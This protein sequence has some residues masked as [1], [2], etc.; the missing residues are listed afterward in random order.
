[1][2]TKQKNGN[3]VPI[4]VAKARKDS[5][6]KASAAEIMARNTETLTRLKNLSTQKGSS[7][8]IP[9]PQ[10]ARWAGNVESI[11][12][13]L[14]AS[15]YGLQDLFAASVSEDFKR[16]YEDAQAYSKNLSAMQNAESS[17]QVV[18]YKKYLEFIE[19]VDA[20]TGESLP[21]LAAE[22][23]EGIAL[24]DG[25]ADIP[26]GCFELARQLEIIANRVGKSSGLIDQFRELAQ[27]R[28]RHLCSGGSCVWPDDSYSF[29]DGYYTPR[30]GKNIGEI[31]EWGGEAEREVNQPKYHNQSVES[32]QE[33]PDDD[34]LLKEGKRSLREKYIEHPKLRRLANN[35]YFIDSECAIYNEYTAPS[36]K[37][38]TLSR[39]SDSL[40]ALP[41]HYAGV[42]IDDFDVDQHI[43]GRYLIRDKAEMCVDTEYVFNLDSL[44]TSEGPEI[45]VAEL[46]HGFHLAIFLYPNENCDGLIPIIH[47]CCDEM[48]H[49]APLDARTISMEAENVVFPKMR[50]KIFPYQTESLM[51]YLKAAVASG[52]LESDWEKSAHLLKQ[53]PLWNVES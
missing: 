41:V 1:M 50:P 43:R 28:E 47:L 13:R 39:F 25:N 44:E 16:S 53:C 46:V 38:L 26:D 31:V 32:L 17:R 22:L 33:M 14:K 24:I 27:V 45:E 23:S 30:P 20:L 49:V 52:E 2:T 36:R 10:R 34:P 37:S 5:K 18:G 3:V 15:G 7:G 40:A 48:A 29:D 12:K 11:V 19:L 42:M 35:T 4:A 6:G 51:S 21:Q 9:K 8:K